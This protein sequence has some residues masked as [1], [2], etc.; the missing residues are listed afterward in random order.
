[1][2][3]THYQRVLE[4]DRQLP[5][6]VRWLTRA[7]SS[8][9]TIGV[10]G[11]FVVGTTAFAHVPVGGRYLWQ[12][13][14]ID[15]TQQSVLTW[16]PLMTAA[17]LLAAVVVWS[18]IRRLAWRW[19]NLGRFVAVLGLAIILVSQSWAFRSQT[20]G[21]AAVPVTP[22]QGGQAD[23]LS[24]TYTTRLGDTHHRQLVVMV[25]GAAPIA[26]PIDDLPRWNDAVGDAMPTIRLHEDPKL[27]TTF[28]F[29]TRI[30]AIAYVADGELT[31][32]PNGT[33]TVTLT[34]T[35]RRDTTALPYP[36]DALVAIRFE[37]E[38]DDGETD[39][40]TVWLPFEPEGTE[41]L[42][43]NR[44]YQVEGLGTVGLAFRP[45]T[46]KMPFAVAASHDGN[47]EKWAHLTLHVAD[48]DDGRLLKPTK[49]EL[50][51]EGYLINFK[52]QIDS[53]NYK[54]YALEWINPYASQPPTTALIRSTMQA[55]QPFITAGLITFVI[56]VA[57]DLLFGFLGPKPKRNAVKPSTAPT[58]N[59]SE[60]KK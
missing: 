41:S 36:A 44:F 47:I 25:G 3:N 51:L 50:G 18:A 29:S 35:D 2:P 12:S 59:A 28:G 27:A 32:Q 40:T 39:T 20:T 48:T 30:T 1:M 55:G 7:M 13:R 26:V 8:W 45:A 53:G 16:W 9:W 15:S 31:D 14:L 19:D 17:W 23:P 58:K 54:N 21:V 10:L 22:T 24:L 11:V 52:A 37:V 56:G 5:L 33:Q 46:K 60:T 43:P 57:F 6:P 42:S 49:H 4:L 38:H 34:P